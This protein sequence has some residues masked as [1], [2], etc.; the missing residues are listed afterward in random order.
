MGSARKLARL[1]QE[2]DA[3]RW[4]CGGVQVN[5]HTLADFRRQSEEALDGLLTGNVASLMAAGVVKL[6][7]VVQDGVRVPVCPGPQPDA[8]D[9]PCAG[10][11]GDRDRYVQN[12]PDGGINVMEYDTKIDP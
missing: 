11:V 10:T 7:S 12:L 5:Y 4:I 3:Y 1:T 6:K 8:D 2:H 9:Q